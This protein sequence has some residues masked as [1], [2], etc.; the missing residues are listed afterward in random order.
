MECVSR[1]SRYMTIL[2]RCDPET[3]RSCQWILG[4]GDSARPHHDHLLTL[5]IQAIIYPIMETPEQNEVHCSAESAHERWWCLTVTRAPR[6]GSTAR[7]KFYTYLRNI[8]LE[9]YDA[10][11]GLASSFS[12]ES[13]IPSPDGCVLGQHRWMNVHRC[14]AISVPLGRVGVIPFE[15][16]CTTC[17]SRV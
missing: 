1:G 12:V 17:I 9:R 6:H 4:C 15:T 10:L 13:T 3:K 14:S 16:A 2:I 11:M 5:G 8:D 7:R